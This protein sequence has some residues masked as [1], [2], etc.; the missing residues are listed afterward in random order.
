MKNPDAATPQALLICGLLAADSQML[1]DVEARLEPRF[2]QVIMR[3]E[4]VPF[5]WT[6]YYNAEMGEGL[7]RRWV[8]FLP[9]VNLLESWKHKLAGCE[10]ENP[11]RSDG[12]R[13]VNIDPGFIRLD[14]LWLFTTKPAGHRTYL[15]EDIW[16]ELTVRFLREGCEEMAWTYP[17][18][19]NAAAQ[20]FFLKARDMLR[21]DLANSQKNQ[22]V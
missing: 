2:G 15:S 1:R 20:A 4:I 11:L 12:K 17:D 10:I 8:V 22:H 18:H 3:S 14:G 5:E 6:D 13:R 21:R 9:P 7:L 16:V 19:R